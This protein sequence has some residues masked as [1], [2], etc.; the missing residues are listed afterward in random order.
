MSMRASILV[1]VLAG[2]VACGSNHP[3]STADGGGTGGATGGAGGGTGGGA[4]G[5]SGMAGAGGTGG[6]AAGS[7]VGHCETG[8]GTGG[9]GG[10][11]AGCDVD[12]ARQALATLGITTVGELRTSTTMVSATLTD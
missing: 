7:A 6:G 2:L 3:A 11:P 1:A 4:A 8:T 5:A 12:V 9:T 10:T